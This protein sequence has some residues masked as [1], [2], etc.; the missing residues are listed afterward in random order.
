[1]HGKLFGHGPTTVVLSNMG[2]ND[3][4]EWEAFAPTLAARGYSVLTYS[5]RYPAYTNSF[6]PTMAIQTVPDL[7]GA[8]AFAR[9]RGAQRIVLIGA[10]LGGIT[11]GK[12]AARLR[13][14]SVVIISAEQDLVGYGLGV[15]PAELAAM[16][17]P[18]IFIASQDDTNTAYAD[19]RS[20]F[21]HAPP[22]KQFHPFPGDVHGVRL[23]DT[24]SGNELRE[25]LLSF[26]SSTAPGGS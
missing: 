10:S 14:T 26:V 7:T 16:T 1:L 4:A 9:Q 17:Q 21:A 2:D 24:A 12:L 15:S 22:P 3:P 20:F 13:A 11:T 19:T 23:F 18:K 6:T 25:L 5:F 8:V